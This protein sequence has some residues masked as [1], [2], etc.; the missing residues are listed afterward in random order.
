MSPRLPDRPFATP[1]DLAECRALLRGG[2]KSFHAAAVVLPQRVRDAATSLYAFCRLA[3]DV[4]DLESDPR[5]GLQRL[6]ERL[7]GA[8][9]GRPHAFAA[10]RAFADVIERFGIP[11]ALPEA[12]LEGFEW[13]AEHRRYED[14]EALTAY[15]TRVA[16]TVGAMMTM[17]MGVRA[18]TVVA[19]ACDLGIAMQ[20]TNIARDVGED[21]RNGRLYLPLD[22]LREAG[23]DPVLWLARPVH[24]PGL[25]SVVQRLLTAADE[26]YQ[27]ADS[28][29]AQLPAACRPGMQAARRLYAEIGREVERR[30]LDS[31]ATRATVARLRKARTLATAFGASLV[32]TP[33]APDAAL[34]AARF[35]V[36]AVASMPRERAR[37]HPDAADWWRI[38]DRSLWVVDLFLR[39]EQR[40]RMAMGLTHQA[41]G[42]EN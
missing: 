24:S 25:A 23:I 40:E 38:A 32:S 15:A 7:A 19:R 14:L 3:D 5:A 34:P 30:G 22:W 26:L 37:S 27:R 1:A 31:V 16:G 9:E 11:R 35:L 12:L 6:R 20:F 29:I 36:D 21:A 17:L 8:Y 41:A 18:P 39:L 2:S 13:D 28:G 4:V 10:D 42:R 33:L